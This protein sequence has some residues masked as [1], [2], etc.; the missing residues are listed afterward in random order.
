MSDYIDAAIAEARAL[1]G[2]PR[3]T[4]RLW[5]RIQARLDEEAR[6]KARKQTR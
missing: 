3:E 5:E 6:A 2:T 1:L 4:E